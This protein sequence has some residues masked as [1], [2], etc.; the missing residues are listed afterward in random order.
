M[1]PYNIHNINIYIIEFKDGDTEP[2]LD[3]FDLYLMEDG[4]FFGLAKTFPYVVNEMSKYSNLEVYNLL[5]LDKIDYKYV[6]MVNLVKDY[7][8]IDKSMDELSNILI[9]ELKSG[10]CDNMSKE[11][12]RRSD[13]IDSIIYYMTN[14]KGKP[15]SMVDIRVKMV[16]D[17]FHYFSEDIISYESIK[18][19]LDFDDCTIKIKTYL[20][21]E[22]IK[23]KF[24][25]YII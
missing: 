9:D 16:D 6:D 3:Y 19:G 17:L 20:S 12:I 22:E 13:Y 23:E 18:N 8:G 5:E 1:R 7:V 24:K 4:Y 11:D 14:Q 10:D 15:I 2:N 25:E 21:E